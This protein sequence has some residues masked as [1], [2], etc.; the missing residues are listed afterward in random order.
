MRALDIGA[1]CR[2][3]NAT[4]AGGPT[5]GERIIREE[6]MV[7]R[8]GLSRSTRWRLE[9]AG[10]FP[11]RVQIGARAHGWRETEFLAWTQSRAPRRK[12]G[13]LVG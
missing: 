2:P 7:A 5:S 3:H 12:S 10:K 9:K 8:S 6:E 11:R 13:D 1:D 4:E